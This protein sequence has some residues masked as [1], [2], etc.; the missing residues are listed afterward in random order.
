MGCVEPT[1][2]L[3][4]AGDSP[5]PSSS[6]QRTSV[7]SGSTPRSV[8]GKASSTQRQAERATKATYADTTNLASR[9]AAFPFFWGMHFDSLEESVVAMRARR[10]R[11]RNYFLSLLCQ[12]GT[13]RD[14]H[15]INI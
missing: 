6:Q 15:P 2:R 9:C 13:H 8:S 5:W 14:L 11:V 4:S 1:H 10:R 7:T 12:T 3:L